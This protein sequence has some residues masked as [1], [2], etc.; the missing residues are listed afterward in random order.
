MIT[1]REAPVTGLV[2]DAVD[3]ALGRACA[4]CEISGRALCPTCLEDIRCVPADLPLSPTVPGRHALPYRGAASTLLLDYK[5]RGNRAL[6]PG[7]GLLLADAVESLL[8]EEVPCSPP[9]PAVLVPV[10][11]HRRPRRGFAALPRI[12]RPAVRLLREAG[13]PV[14]ARPLLRRARN[15]GPLKGMD[16]DARRRAVPG[17]MVGRPSGSAAPVIVVDDVV[18]T[19]STLLEAIRA[20]DEAGIPVAGIAAIAHAEHP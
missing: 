11:G 15:H 3:L 6:A 5:E 9:T 20:L 8:L 16:R 1:L 10:P 19:G 12:I 7:L 13:L 17:S 14:H 2:T 4:L 18:T